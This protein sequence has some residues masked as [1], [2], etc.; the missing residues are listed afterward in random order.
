MRRAKFRPPHFPI[1]DANPEEKEV[2]A[3]KSKIASMNRQQV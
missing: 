3:T 2:E 1:I